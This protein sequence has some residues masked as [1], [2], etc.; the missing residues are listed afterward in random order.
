MFPSIH[1]SIHPSIIIMN[2]NDFFSKLAFGATFKKTRTN[3]PSTKLQSNDNGEQCLGLQEKDISKS[4]DFF[5][6]SA[7][8]VEDTKGGGR[9]EKRKLDKVPAIDAGEKRKKRSEK[10]N[11]TKSLVT[12]E[13]EAREWRSLHK[14]KLYEEST[15]VPF[16][17]TSIDDLVEAKGFCDLKSLP[18][19]L[20]KAEYKELTPIQMQAIPIIMSSRE[21]IACAPTGSGKSM[22]FLLP[23]LAKLQKN[24][25]SAG[26]RALIISPTKELAQQILRECQ[27]LAAGEKIKA[28]V[29][30]KS[31]MASA[32]EQQKSHDILIS[33]PMRLVHAIQSSA[34]DLATVKWL[35]LDESDK[36]LEE[37]FLEQVDEIMEACSNRKLYRALFSATISSGVE[38]L[39]KT[40]MKDPIRIVIGSK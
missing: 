25:K 17:L 35:I 4:L 30:S 2:A 21:L 39:A 11:C 20:E 36:L 1:P 34:I 14:I 27:K 16:P 24:S 8:T 18:K 31:N 13:E 38:A 12:N 7:A 40:F 10:S 23:L 37:G 22:A 33:T 3:S 6:D 26:F 9:I 15:L 19:S 5:G 32:K 28:M 29:L